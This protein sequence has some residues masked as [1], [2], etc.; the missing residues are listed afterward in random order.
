[1]PPRSA[2]FCLDEETRLELDRRIAASGFGGYANH[3]AWLTALGHREIT[4]RVL[5][6]YGRHL[7]KRLEDERRIA[8]EAAAV[9]RLGAADRV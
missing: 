1:M 5:W 3:A 8:I 4:A 6:R 2:V 9:A 7:K